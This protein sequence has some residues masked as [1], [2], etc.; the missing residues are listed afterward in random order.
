[1]NHARFSAIYSGLTSVAKKVYEAV[2]IAEYWPA[3][4]IIYE[5]DRLN[6]HVDHS[7]VRGCLR[8]LKEAGLIMEVNKQGEFKRVPVRMPASKTKTVEEEEMNNK[9]TAPATC[10]PKKTTP[11]DALGELAQRAVRMADMLKDLASDISDA[12]VEIQAQLEAGDEDVQKLRQ[13][14]TLLKGIV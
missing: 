9:N 2:P 5:M 6:I 4:K 13:L 10:H 12:A 8:S 14:Q 7:V 11:M 3:A 1:M